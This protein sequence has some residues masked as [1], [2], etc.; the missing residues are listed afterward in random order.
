M[1]GF[2]D[3]FQVLTLILFIGL[4]I[5]WF[6]FN[7]YRSHFS[8]KILWIMGII[9]IIIGIFLSIYAIPD[10]SAMFGV[11]FIFFGVFVLPLRN[12]LADIK[13]KSI[14]SNSKILNE[15]RDESVYDHSISKSKEIIHKGKNYKANQRYQK[16]ID[17]FVKVISINPN[18]DASAESWFELGEINL[19]R[20]R[21]PEALKCYKR[22][23]E[24]KPNYSDALERINEVKQK[25]KDIKNEKN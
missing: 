3:Y 21:V 10:N 13:S 4:A 20:N 23:V 7:K 2:W 24:I 22:A 12:L 9:I 8:K 11:V 18:S 17:A 14:E 5:L 1:Q 25:L 6:F 16:A 19:I 15:D